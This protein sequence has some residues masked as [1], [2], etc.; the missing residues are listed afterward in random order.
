LRQ[1]TLWSNFSG[2][3]WAERSKL[4]GINI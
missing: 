2:K 3:S 4:C 1:G